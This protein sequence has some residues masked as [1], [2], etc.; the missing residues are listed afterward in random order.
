MA[1]RID[2][3]YTLDLKYL[4]DEASG[5][6]VRCV[7]KDKSAQKLRH[8]PIGRRAGGLYIFAIRRQRGAGK[9]WYVGMNEG[10]DQGSLYKEALTNEKLRKYAR[11][12]AEEDSG[13]A[14]L[15]F[16]SPDDRRSDDIP[17]LETF[18]IWLAR[19]RNP[20]L[21]NKRKFSLTPRLLHKHLHQHQITGVLN[22]RAGHPGK[23]ADT[24][25]K[26][27]GWNSPMHIG[28][29]QE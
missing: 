12:L 28:R 6:R 19:Q 20:H 21:L 13:S 15:F 9:P 2:G 14:L 11:A 26:M 3:P 27:I 7:N 16:L 10:T 24:F 22:A 1:F 18:L 25:R 23:A 5:I 29:L 4:S 17:E 8:L